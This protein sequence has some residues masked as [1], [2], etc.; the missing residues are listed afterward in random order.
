MRLGI[1]SYTYA[2]ACGMP[3]HR[4]AA[5][6]PPPPRLTHAGLLERAAALG[7]GVVQ[8][9][10]NLPLDG[11]SSGK[12]D[13]LARLAAER[14]LA[15]E[16]G[17]RGIAP[18]E[19]LERH[20]A[21]AARLGSPILRVVV[22]TAEH[23]PAPE[24][25]VATLRGVLPVLGEAGVVLAIEN[26]DRFRAAVLRGIVEALGSDRVGVCLDTVN[27][28]GALEGPGVV[29]GEVGHLVVNLHIKDFHVAR[30]PYSMGFV[31]E[32]RPAG[33]G[34]LNVPW[35]LEALEPH[36]G[37]YNAILELWTPPEPRIEDTLRKEMAWAEESVRYL[38]TLISG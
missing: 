11:L 9:C 31:V 23:H 8:I 34:M 10:D 25:V 38:R 33:Q 37:E 1:S 14:G 22:D 7:V 27:S 29:V 30:V 5:G 26:H 3:G 19:H 6:D 24:E 16:V 2:W 15:I 28:F 21:L 32:G 35:L 36:G 4:F 12:V 18:A 13:A 17:T 20:I